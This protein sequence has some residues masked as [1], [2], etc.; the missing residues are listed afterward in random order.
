MGLDSVELIMEVEKHFS[1]SIP[2]KKAERILNINDF[3]NHIF[4]DELTELEDNEFKK[5][6]LKKI[7][8][9]LIEI[10]LEIEKPV[11]FNDKAEILLGKLNIDNYKIFQ[12]KL[13]LELPLDFYKGILSYIFNTESLKDKLSKKTIS[14]FIDALLIHNYRN[15]IIS[16]RKLTRYIVYIKLGGIVT[17]KLGIDPIEI[18]PEKQF[19]RDYGID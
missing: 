1:I 11:E 10:K 14:E 19:V 4:G 16:N 6:I 18:E 2:D 17:E 7:N 9:T 12:E 3:V 13:N 8:S 5:S 15:Q